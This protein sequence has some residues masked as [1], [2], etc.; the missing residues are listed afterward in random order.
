MLPCAW[1]VSLC[2]KN[3]V[4]VLNNLSNKRG[5]GDLCQITY[6][7]TPKTKPML[8]VYAKVSPPPPPLTTLIKW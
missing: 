6:P 1:D 8:P 2:H 7:L 3:V 4:K 5:G